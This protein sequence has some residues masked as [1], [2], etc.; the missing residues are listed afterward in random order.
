[1]SSSTYTCG[2]IF[3]I[4]IDNRE[5]L[6]IVNAL[7]LSM[8]VTHRRL[9]TKWLPEMR[10]G[11]NN[12]AT[13]LRFPLLRIKIFREKRVFFRWKNKLFGKE[14]HIPVVFFHCPSPSSFILVCKLS[15]WC[16]RNISNMRNQYLSLFLTPRSQTKN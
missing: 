4:P 9:S 6:F 8:N 14:C 12:I 16:V 3:L 7:Q 13:V 10:K 5:V 15:S 1:M 2:S 11:I